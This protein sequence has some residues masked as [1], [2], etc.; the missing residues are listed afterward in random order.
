MEAVSSPMVMTRETVGECR[1]GVAQRLLGPLPLGDVL[2]HPNPEQRLAPLVAHERHG[3]VPPNQ[4]AVFAVVPFFNVIISRWPLISSVNRCQ[5]SGTILRVRDLRKRHVAELLRAI[6]EQPLERAITFEGLPRGIHERHADSRLV[7]QRMELPFALPQRFFGALT[8]NELT[9]LAADG[10]QRVELCRLGL[11][12][13]A[14][15]ELHDTEGLAAEQNREHDGAMQAHP[16]GDGRAQ[17]IGGL[18][19]IT[20]PGGLGALPDTLPAGLVRA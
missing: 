9:N 4:T 2:H 15:E 12:N 13:R 3:Q 11:P 18:R 5:S 20:N 1:L 17:E 6:A 7:E 8:L 19:D 16:G 14:A 10:G